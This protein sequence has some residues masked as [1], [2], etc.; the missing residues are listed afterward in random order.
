MG[1]GRLIQKAIKK[2]GKENFTKKI[3]W[4]CETEEEM[5][6]KEKELVVLNENTYNMAPGGIGG[7]GKLLNRSGFL[8]SP[9]TK[10]K[11]RLRAIGRS[12]G[13]KN[14]NWKRN[15]PQSSRDKMSESQSLLWEIT[16]PNKEIKIVKNLKKFC[17]ENNLDH[18]SLHSVA[19]G[20]RGSKQHKGF[21]CKSLGGA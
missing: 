1:S 19:S 5:I 14:G 13:D 16:Y 3:I 11:M 2:H 15:F 8:H 4:V 9:E 18:G 17:Q 20:R 6:E 21:V 10:E 7:N 12:V